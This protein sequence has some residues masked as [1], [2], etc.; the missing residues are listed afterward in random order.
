VAISP[1]AFSRLALANFVAMVLIIATGAAVRLT[2]SGLGCPDWPNCF[3]HQLTAP[4]GQVHPVIEDANRLVTVLL[5]VLTV[6]TL[7]AALLRSP[8]RRDLT[9]LSSGLVGGVVADALLGAL[10]VY[11]KLN[12]WL[13][14]GHMALSLA[15]VVLAGVLFHRSTHRFGPDARREL[16]CPWTVPLARWLWVALAATLLAGMA[17]TGSG[18]H[19]GGSQGQDVARRL[20]F[21]LH[22]A[23]WVH[24]VCAV[25]FLGIVAGAYL[26]LARTGAASRVTT[27][28]KRLLVVGVAQG[29]V[30]V[31]QYATHL[32]VLLVELHVLGAVSITIGVLHFQLAQVAR[33]REVGLE[34]AVAPDPASPPLVRL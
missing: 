26:V 29:I 9:W 30:G 31:V 6:V 32:P 18:P 16:R 7:L 14:S 21:A 1:R 33:D 19:S 13:V 4:I 24:S 23:A 10:V 27:G 8:R 2:G 25:A 11:T 5:V 12:P 20:P 3:R 22:S 15:M 28:A 17:T 34:R